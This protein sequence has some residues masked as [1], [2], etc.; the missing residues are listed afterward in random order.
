MDRRLNDNVLL[1]ENI[2]SLKV[3]WSGPVSNKAFE[4]LSDCD[5]LRKLGIVISRATTNWVN[6]RETVMRLHFQGMR[7]VRLYDALGLDE[8]CD[9]GNKFNDVQVLHIQ[10]KQAH[11]RTDEDKR[12]LQSLLSHKLT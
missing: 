7:Q 5:A 6:K 12:S 3:H 9:L 4:K 10:T 1:A 2:R 11:R 8:L